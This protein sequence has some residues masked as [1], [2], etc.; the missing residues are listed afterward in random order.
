MGDPPSDDVPPLIPVRVCFYDADGGWICKWVAD[1]KGPWDFICP[2]KEWTDIPEKLK[3]WLRN[4]PNCVVTEAG[5]V[6]H[7]E[8][9]RGWIGDPDTGPGFNPR[10]EWWREFCEL[11]PPDSRIRFNACNIGAGEDGQSLY[12][13]CVRNGGSHCEIY[14]E[15]GRI[16]WTPWGPRVIPY[17][18]WKLP[19]RKFRYW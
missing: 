12:E 11:L 10:E 18:W 7:G 13:D 15:P 6:C 14:L 5:I 2:I 19:K 9:G 16:V 17:R 1:C 4:N 8:P 3:E